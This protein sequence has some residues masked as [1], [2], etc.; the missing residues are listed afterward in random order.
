MQGTTKI[1]EEITVGPQPDRQ[2]IYEFGKE[3][4]KTI[5]NFRAPHEQDQP[6]SPLAED[7]IVHEAG[8]EYL[9]IPMSM[10]SLNDAQIDQ[11]REKYDSLPKPIFAHCKSGKRAGAAAMMNLAVEQGKSG[12]QTLQKAKE[13]GFQCHKP[14]LVE[15][16]KSYVDSHN[17]SA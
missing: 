1:N 6:I 11:F 13:M 9:H 14:E 10:N 12:E 16:V 8:M 5:V 2:E 7:E 4:F 3:G 15:F 17:G